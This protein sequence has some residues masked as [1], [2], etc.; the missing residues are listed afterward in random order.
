MKWRSAAMSKHL[1][2]A[3]M[4][5]A[6]LMTM[7]AGAQGQVQPPLQCDRGPITKVFGGTVWNV[8]SCDDDLSLVFLSASGSP[9]MP[10]YFL[11]TVSNGRYN[12][13]G[14]GTGQ[15]E[16][17]SRAFEDLKQLTAQQIKTLLEEV[18]ATAKSGK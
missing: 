9:A 14:E 12:L 13:S 15:K 2:C 4:V 16:F 17:T 7:G 8:F 5:A 11:F 6:L 10:F 1:A 18:R 3:T